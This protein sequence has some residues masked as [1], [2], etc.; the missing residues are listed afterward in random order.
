MEILKLLKLDKASK[1]DRAATRVAGAMSRE[2]DALINTLSQEVDKLEVEKEELENLDV[3][4]MQKEN[5]ASK[6]VAKYQEIDTKIELAT[7]KL[8]IARRTKD[9]FFTNVIVKEGV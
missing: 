4:E 7:K 6:W 1:D 5:A 3:A 9:K 8:Q 2:Q